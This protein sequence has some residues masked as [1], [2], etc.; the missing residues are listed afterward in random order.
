MLETQSPATSNIAGIGEIFSGPAITQLYN[1]PG[2][3]P[4]GDPRTPD[5]LVTPNIGVTYSGSSK[6]LA[7]HGGFSHDDTNVVLIV[8][9]PGTIPAVVNTPVTTSQ[10]APTILN[11]LGLDPSKLDAVKSEGTAALPGK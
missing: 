7:E 6:K 8:S 3:P 1:A 4:N 10:I 2:L 5:I 9:N 11:A